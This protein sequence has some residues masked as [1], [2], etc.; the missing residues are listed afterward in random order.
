ME[1]FAEIR[2]TYTDGIDEIALKLKEFEGKPL[3]L[4]EAATKL[5]LEATVRLFT[6]F[7]GQIDTKA[8]A[9]GDKAASAF[10]LAATDAAE[11]AKVE[12][13]K[14]Q[15]EAGL[16]TKAGYQKALSDYAAYMHRR[17][18]TFKAGTK[19]RS[20]AEI[21]AFQADQAATQNNFKKLDAAATAA[22]A[23]SKKRG[24]QITKNG[25]NGSAVYKAGLQVALRY[26]EGRLAGLKG[27]DAQT[28]AERETIQQTID[29]LGQT[30]ENLVND[31][32]LTAA[33]DKASGCHREGWPAGSHHLRRSGW[34]L[35]LFQGWGRHQGALDGAAAFV[36]SLTEVFKTGNEDIDN[37]TSAFVSGVQSTLGA[38][39]KGT[40]SGPSWPAS[41]R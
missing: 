18:E 22:L 10:T 9:A 6:G 12:L 25:G 37:V 39:A 40:G 1:Q 38:L 27:T 29:D 3:S 23:L 24:E 16:I 32:P 26:W 19:E 11:Q 36:G 4:D 35:C 20:E 33:L 30:I 17:V 31:S 13:A 2:K 21:A 8:Q 41:P 5:G 34:T 15:R 14:S 7:V 28:S